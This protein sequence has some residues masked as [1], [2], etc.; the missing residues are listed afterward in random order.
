MGNNA[1]TG[2][3]FLKPD[4]NECQKNETQSQIIVPRLRQNSKI[5]LRQETKKSRQEAKKD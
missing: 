1:G 4:K 2:C 3:L 5:K